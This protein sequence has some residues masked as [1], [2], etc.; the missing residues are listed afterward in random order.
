MVEAGPEADWKMEN[1]RVKAKIK[2]LNRA[3]EASER[4]GRKPL[5]AM[6]STVKSE[7]KGAKKS[8]FCTRLRPESEEKHRG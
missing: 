1:V 4:P 3:S 7:K 5:K 6:S 2:V 8:L